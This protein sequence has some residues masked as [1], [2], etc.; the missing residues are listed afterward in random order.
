MKHSLGDEQLK[1]KLSAEDSERVTSKVTEV[2]NWLDSNADAD[3]SDYER[4]QKE[5]EDLFNPIMQK[6]YQAAGGVPRSN[7]SRDNANASSAGNRGAAPNVDEV[8]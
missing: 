6:V 1:D 5:V 3:T 4:K 2:Q 8:D 7:C